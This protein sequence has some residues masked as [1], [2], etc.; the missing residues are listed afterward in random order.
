LFL[1]YDEVMKRIPWLIIGAICGALVGFMLMPAVAR[2]GIPLRDAM[3]PICG[4]FV[5][6]AAGAI[7]RYVLVRRR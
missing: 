3:L 6:A 4:T 1:C 7:V 5:G 2:I